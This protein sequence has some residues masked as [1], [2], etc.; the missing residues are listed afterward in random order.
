MCRMP[1]LAFFLKRFQYDSF[2]ICRYVFFFY[3]WE[4][5]FFFNG[6]YGFVV[7]FDVF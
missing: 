5:D 1:F 3:G 6:F 4:H 7:G 2:M